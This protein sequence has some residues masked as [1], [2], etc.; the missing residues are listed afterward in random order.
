M[1]SSRA[2]GQHKT[3]VRVHFADSRFARSWFRHH[4]PRVVFKNRFPSFLRRYFN[5]RILI[6]EVLGGDSDVEI[7]SSSSLCA[8]SRSVTSLGEKRRRG[9]YYKFRLPIHSLETRSHDRDLGFPD[10]GSEFRDWISREL[11]ASCF[12]RTDFPFYGKG[13]RV[14]M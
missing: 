12:Q 2:V 1:L 6:L 4:R 9:G 13:I 7:A 11:A 14:Y 3:A 10:R 5:S 8:L